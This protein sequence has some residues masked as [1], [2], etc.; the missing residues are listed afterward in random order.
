M[1]KVCKFTS[2]C[3][4]P[5][6]K[7]LSEWGRK[8]GRHILDIQGCKVVSS[9][10][11]RLWS[12]W[13]SAQADKGLRCALMPDGRPTCSWF[14]SWI[15]IWIDKKLRL[16]NSMILSYL[17]GNRQRA[18][19]FLNFWMLQSVCCTL[20]VEIMYFLLLSMFV[21]IEWIYSR[22]SYLEHL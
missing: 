13:S 14:D 11:R 4:A 21:S 5:S 6:K 8:H 17:E 7:R 1:T 15:Y 22:N 19:L 18:K 3:K 9:G 16:K 12:G 10:Q 2:L 20:K